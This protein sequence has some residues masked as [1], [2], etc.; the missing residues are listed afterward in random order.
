M[1]F[2]VSGLLLL[3]LLLLLQV[4]L[5]PESEVMLTRRILDL[6]QETLEGAPTSVSQDRALL[7][8][9][10]TR[11]E[12]KGQGRPGELQQQQ[13]Q[14]QR[15]SGEPP[16]ASA[17][18]EGLLI[19][20]VGL[21]PDRAEMQEGR[22][23]RGALYSEPWCGGPST[24][25]ARNGVEAEDRRLRGVGG[26]CAVIEGRQDKKVAAGLDDWVVVEAAEAETGRE[27]RTREVELPGQGGEALAA[28]DAP[29]P[30]AMTAQQAAAAAAAAGHILRLSLAVQYRLERKLLLQ[31]VV[32]DLEAQLCL[33]Q[34][35]AGQ[36]G[37]EGGDVAV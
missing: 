22:L 32:G 5:D 30:P 13:Q 15:G 2:G 21:L 7:A 37:G 6:C 12:A 31:R 14:Q 27:S 8:A 24:G 18:R 35:H 34:G 33:L 11:W 19:E 23:G 3:L 10:C 20:T 36:A 4:N 9:L 1:L 17:D 25:R 29:P 26:E 16:G 28:E